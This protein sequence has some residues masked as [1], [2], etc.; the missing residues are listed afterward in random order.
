[1]CADTFCPGS[2]EILGHFITQW[3]LKLQQG[4]YFPVEL[5]WDRILQKA[6]LMCKTAPTVRLFLCSHTKKPFWWCWWITGQG[7]VDH[8]ERGCNIAVWI[9]AMPIP[10]QGSMRKGY[11]SMGQQFC[12]RIRCGRSRGER[13]RSAEQSILSPIVCIYHGCIIDSSF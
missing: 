2:L 12:D 6:S 8:G 5:H 11:S 4:V 9:Q 10:R 7:Q 3:T 13:Q 1:M